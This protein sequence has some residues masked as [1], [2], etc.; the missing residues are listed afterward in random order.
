MSSVVSW[1]YLTG[2][3]CFANPPLPSHKKSMTL[4]WKMPICKIV[5]DLRL[6]CRLSAKLLLFL[7]SW[8]T[9][10][11]Q[12]PECLAETFLRLN[13]KR[14]VSLV[15]LLWLQRHKYYRD[16]HRWS[17]SGFA[18]TANTSL[19]SIPIHNMKAYPKSITIF[20]MPSEAG[21]EH[22]AKESR[23]EFLFHSLN[24]HH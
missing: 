19:E 1:W 17:P 23:A 24:F 15:F 16:L 11:V 5:I 3:D 6:V 12:R 4:R 21:I 8:W 20:W 22:R 10:S 9:S 14:R 7:W 18:D 2:T 13:R